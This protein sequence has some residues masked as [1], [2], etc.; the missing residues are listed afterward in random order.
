MNTLQMSN[1]IEQLQQKTQLT[2][3]R[4]T[5]SHTDRKIFTFSFT[6]IHSLVRPNV[7][8]FS[9][10][11][12]YQSECTQSLHYM[13]IWQFLHV[14][15][16]YSI[17]QI[18]FCLIKLHYIISLCHF[19]VKNLHFNHVFEPHYPTPLNNFTQN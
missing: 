9:S 1:L 5:C 16:L 15:E 19:P 18:S 7:N 6:A 2:P 10:T 12:K 11:F 13:N 14:L 3:Y 4:L 17:S 8:T